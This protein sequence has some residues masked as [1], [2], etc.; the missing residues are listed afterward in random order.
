MVLIGLE[1]GLR[2]L[3]GLDVQPMWALIRKNKE[4]VV[5]YAPVWGLPALPNAMLLV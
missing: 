4:G 2:V 1:L 5:S 3:K